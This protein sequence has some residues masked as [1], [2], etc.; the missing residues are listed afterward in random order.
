MKK[1]VLAV[2]I[3]V[4]L[5]P[6]PVTRA[7]EERDGLLVEILCSINNAQE[8]N[9]WGAVFAKVSPTELGAMIQGYGQ[10]VL[11]DVDHATAQLTEE[12]K[13][14]IRQHGRVWFFYGY[15]MQNPELLP[16]AVDFYN[17]HRQSIYAFMAPL[18]S[19]VCD[20]A[21][22]TSILEMYD[23]RQGFMP[24]VPTYADWFPVSQKSFNLPV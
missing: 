15:A 5:W 6:T 16:Y 24:G 21:W 12:Q 22:D 8:V 2:F 3:I 9:L 17:F 13:A 10:G 1:L 19:V 20:L 7:Q 11:D 14:L 4:L 23:P 18:N